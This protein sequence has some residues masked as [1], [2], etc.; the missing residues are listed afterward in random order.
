MPQIGGKRRRR[1]RR[2][3][4]RK[5]APP[6]AGGG[7]RQT[8]L[9]S[10]AP[11]LLLQPQEG[12]RPAGAQRAQAWQGGRSAGAAA[13][14]R[15]PPQRAAAGSSKA[16][17]LEP[18]LARGSATP[19]CKLEEVGQGRAER[20]GATRQAK[21][22]GFCGRLKA[23]E[24]SNE[25]S[26]RNRSAEWCVGRGARLKSPSIGARAASL[27]APP[28]TSMPA[29]TWLSVSTVSSLQT[30]AR[31]PSRGLGA[32]EARRR[33]ASGAYVASPPWARRQ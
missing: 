28:D 12:R 22:H 33:R 4:R 23:G 14:R 24:P 7:S 27:A 13:G 10:P 21:R 15:R 8:A 17:L 18:L 20:G 29:H 9:C 30:V 3:H 31:T 5:T 1:Q 25:A 16:A 2:R 26:T 32:T 6:P 19:L 11:C